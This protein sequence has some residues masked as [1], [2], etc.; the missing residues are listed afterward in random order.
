[1][2]G[3]RHEDV[4]RRDEGEDGSLFEQRLGE[5]R[6]RAAPAPVLERVQRR[7][8][9]SLVRAEARPGGEGLAAPAAR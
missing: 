4:A 9:R 8:Q 5:A 2:Q 3:H 6:G 1:M 7:P